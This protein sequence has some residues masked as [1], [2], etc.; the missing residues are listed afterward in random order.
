MYLH[1]TF[2]Q[3]SSTVRYAKISDYAF[4]VFCEIYA[5]NF[6]KIYKIKNKDIADNLGHSVVQTSR[7]ISELTIAGII[8]INGE[9]DRRTISIAI[10][11]PVKKYDADSVA[12]IR[13]LF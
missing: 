12:A 4:R 1:N 10:I 6:N 8:E 5:Y 7:A 9:R 11:Y 13:G 2:S 3:V